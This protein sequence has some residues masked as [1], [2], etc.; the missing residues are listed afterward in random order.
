[1]TTDHDTTPASTDGRRA[2]SATDQ[3]A[4]LTT[5]EIFWRHDVH[6]QSEAETLAQLDAIQIRGTFR[7]DG[8]FLGYDYANQCW[9]DE[10][11]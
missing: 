6:G 4:P 7:A 2:P 8:S 11:A 9:L 10:P 3:L 1:M 5:I